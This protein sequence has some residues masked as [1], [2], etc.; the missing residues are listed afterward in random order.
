M[1]ALAG[2]TFPPLT[3]RVVDAAH[4]INATTMTRLDSQLQALE[5]KSSIQLVVATVPSLQGQDIDTFANEMFRAWKLGQKTTNNGVLLLV[6]PKEHQVRIEVGYGLEGTLTDVL[7]NIIITHAIVPRFK[8]GD[9]SGGISSGVDDIIAVL[10]GDKTNWVARQPVRPDNRSSPVNLLVF[11]FLL[12]LFM[13]MN[14]RAQVSGGRRASMGAS[15]A[16]GMIGG[17]LGG[18]ER[19][20]FSSGGDFGSFSGG[21]GSSGGGGASGSW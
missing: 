16:G 7:S 17:M 13:F 14:W 9:L 15:F 1:A 19:G 8:Q 10:S 21:G 2:L 11:G 20:G 18:M 4:V 6:V 3:G 5:S 12:L